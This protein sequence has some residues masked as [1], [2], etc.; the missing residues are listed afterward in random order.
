MEG[1]L[2]DGMKGRWQCEGGEGFAKKEAV[3]FNAFQ[4]NWKGF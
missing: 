3:L 4:C 2:I 1:A